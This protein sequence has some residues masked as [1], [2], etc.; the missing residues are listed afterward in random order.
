LFGVLGADKALMKRRAWP[1]RSWRQLLLV[2]TGVSVAVAMVTIAEMARENADRHRR[3]QVLVETIRA[4]G[5]QLN[6][7]RTQALADALAS[8]TGRVHLS[9]PIVDS[10]FRVWGELSDALQQLRALESDAQTATLQRDA[11]ALFLVGT[12]TLASANGLLLGN[13]LH[14]EEVHFGPV[15]SRLDDAAQGASTY[16]RGV[17]DRASASAQTAFVGSLVLGLFA[18]LVIVVRFQRLGRKAAVE[19]ERHAIETRS[20]ARLSALIEHST[21]VATVIGPDLVVQWQAAS[22]ERMLGYEADVV[23]GHPL[24]NIVHPDDV[25]LVERFLAASLGRRGSHTLSARFSHAAGGSRTVETVV[26]NRVDDSAVG[27]LVLSMRDVTERKVL[28]DE[29]RHQAFHDSLTGLANRALFEDRLSH[30]MAIAGR[31]RRAFAVLFLDLDDFK[32]INDSLGHAR[33]DELLRATANRIRGILRLSDTAARLGGDEFAV[34][35]EAGEAEAPAAARR[36][37]DALAAPFL[38]DGR[39][40]RITA[41][42]GLAL[43]GAGVSVEELLRNADM[44]M[45]AAKS[46]GKA[47]IRAFEPSMHRRVLERLELTGEMR[48]ALDAGEFELDYQPIVELRSGRIVGVEALVRW[49]HPERARLPPDQFI[50]LAEETGLI[51]PLGQWVLETACAEARRWQLAFPGHPLQLSVNVSTRQLHEPNFIDTVEE[52]LR[53][54]ELAPESLAIEITEGL[55]LGDRNEVVAQLQGLKALGLR[56]A[57]DD[58]GTGYSSLSHLRHFPIDILK[59]DKSFVDGIDSD[60]GKAKLVHGIVNLGDSLMLDVVAEGI[61]QQGQANEFSGMRSPLAQGFLFFPPLPGAEI[62]ALL[63]SPVTQGAVAATSNS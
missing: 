52:I 10:G 58:F 26:D 8:R 56:V 13:A 42:M 4:S 35:I 48:A 41:S 15:L 50:G 31:R 19:A 46:D 34:L 37:L 12:R 24:T 63:A 62:E 40:L 22:V 44:A 1:R 23:I 33:G 20:E 36:I 61:E 60:P 47:S 17:A 49:Q 55:L 7:I 39:E 38:I 27:G 53:V 30:A 21:D 6:A 54:T 43:S 16:E 45:Y 25:G 3:A 18:L 14:N 5:Q 32:T 59:I 29:L 2:V 57:V 9:A 28:E 11:G 51:V